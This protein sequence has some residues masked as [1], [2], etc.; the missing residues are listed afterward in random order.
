[1]IATE[2]G[3]GYTWHA[4]SQSNKLTPWSNDP[5]ANP[6]TDAI[7]LRD[8]ATGALWT[9]TP[10][11]IR[12]AG[13]YRT[14]HG[15]GYTVWERISHG[16]SAELTVFVVP[17][18]HPIQ[19]EEGGSQPPVR[20]QILK[21][22]NTT[23]QPRRLTATAYAA[24]TL[25]VDRE[26]MQMHVVTEWDAEND[27]LI[28]TNGYRPDFGDYATFLA[29]NLPVTSYAA[30][31]TEFLGR[32]GTTARPPPCAA[33]TISLF[34]ARSA[35]DTTPA[36]P[37]Q[38]AI[39]LAPNAETEV[40]FLLGET[41]TRESVAPLLAQFRA[42]GA[43][44]AA[45]DAAKGFWHATLDTVK[46]E[47][48]DE[49]VDLLLNRWLL[50]QD[51]SCRVWGRSAFYQSGGAFGFRDQLQDVMGV[52]YALPEVARAQIV[53]S[54]AH[55]FAEGD[56]QHWWHPPGGAG[57][58]TKI[59]DDLLWLPYVTAQ[60]VRVTGDVG[61]LDEQIP[62]LTG[63]ILGPDEHEAF[64]PPTVTDEKASLLEHCRRAIA[65]GLTKSPL[66]GLPLIGGGDWNDGLNRVGIGGKGESV[67]LAWF[68]VHTLNDWAELLDHKAQTDEATKARSGRQRRWARQNRR[69]NRLGRQMVPP[70]LLRRRYAAR[71]VHQ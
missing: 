62:F 52:L 60:Y 25:G 26:E 53:L 6:T 48:P 15:Q 34:L 58:R 40:V 70:W 17:G 55:Q 20:L 54:A 32:N 47:T 22:R 18:E 3:I 24:W 28:A 41:N 27:C 57:V 7:Y 30:D 11:P 31:R 68:L 12:E 59:S 13:M 37:F 10:L 46:V 5:T 69:G 67:W 66:H 23:D 4:N 50:Y 56:V 29:S 44:R 64:F 8:E 35:R 1:M 36:P 65:K 42:P 21:L 38:M 51:L 43:A 63:K 49:G 14:R 2:A 9:T 33:K 39:D 71:L 16:I 19:S 61:I 45:L